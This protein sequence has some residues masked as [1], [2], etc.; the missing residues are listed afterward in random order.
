M[1][2]VSRRWILR[3]LLVL[4]VCML[5]FLARPI[6]H[7]LRTASRERPER[8]AEP[9]GVLN[10][11]SG[12]SRTPI[13]EVVSVRD[14]SDL[15]EALKQA[16]ADATPVSVA[17]SR[18][19]M[20][21][22]SLV[23]D[24][25][26]LDMTG[27]GLVRY[28]ARDRTAIA[29]GGATWAT[30]LAEL[31]RHG[32][33]PALAPCMSDATVGGCL[34]VNAY[35]WQPGLP[36]IAAGVSELKVMLPDGALWRCSG[37]EN[38]DLFEAVVGGY[39]LVGV[40]VEATLTTVPN[41]PC[42]AE[43]RLFAVSDIGA[44]LRR[45]A[46]DSEVE[47]AFADVSITAER[48]LDRAVLTT[49]RVA[50]GQPSKLRSWGDG[51]I[52]RIAEQGAISDDYGRWVNW[53]IKSRLPRLR[54]PAGLSR[55]SLFHR[56]VG[57]DLHPGISSSTPLLTL[58]VPPDALAAL[59]K[60]TALILATYETE[61]LDATVCLVGPDRI[62][63]VRYATADVCVL[64]LKLRDSTRAGGEYRVRE[65]SKRIIERAI[66]LGGGMFLAYRRHATTT[67][68]VQAYGD[69]AAFRRRKVRY[70]PDERLQSNLYRAY[71]RH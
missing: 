57:S 4:V 21:G 55:N 63:L 60:Q 56:A 49:F 23:R 18:L 10:D 36:P 19:S 40:I 68:I 71:L 59:M 26:V 31:D 37:T 22:Q 53:Q 2:V 34:S 32:R 52:S 48:M 66:A 35:G 27:Y 1:S 14:L 12:M 61:L 51:W 15:K 28:R 13:A 24:G 65:V 67:Q 70:D 44:A 16:A 20:G 54:R 39:G 62:A 3:S 29:G 7:F 47:L 50:A 43:S 25:L 41:S 69:L 8:A 33:S 6:A 38:G 46:A 42:A 9:P 45:A 5:A 17:G 58:M 11:A 64:Q 30:V